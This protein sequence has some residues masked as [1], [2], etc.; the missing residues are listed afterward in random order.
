MATEKQI[1]ANRRNAA[2][3][4]GPRTP[5]GKARSRMNALRHGL[6]C[7]GGNGANKSRNGDD[8]Q[9]EIVDALHQVRVK[10]VEMLAELNDLLTSEVTDG[11]DRAIKRIAA[12][13]RY[14]SRLYAALKSSPHSTS[15]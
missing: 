6:S 10:R 7:L 9:L 4:T 14:E 3:S 12:L 11:I 15:D 8:E 2:R 5:K 1:A 13:S